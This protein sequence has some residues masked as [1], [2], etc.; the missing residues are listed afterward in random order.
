MIRGLNDPTKNE[1]ESQAEESDR[2]AKTVLFVDDEPSILEMR[3]LVFETIGYSVLTATSGEGA[4][5]LFV[6]HSVDA[7][8]LDYLMPG[9]DG[10]ETAL[11]LRKLRSDVPIILSSGCLTVPERVLQLVSSAVGKTAKPE[12]LID[13]LAQQ[14]DLYSASIQLA[15][16]TRHPKERYAELCEASDARTS[17]RRIGT[18]E[19]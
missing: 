14:L 16:C 5:E 4:L 13:A 18:G 2:S 15:D 9:M 3:R 12:A 17:R 6:T 1:K 7:V 19:P 10:E 8:V 11:R